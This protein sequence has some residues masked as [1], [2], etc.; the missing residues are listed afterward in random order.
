MFSPTY[1]IF[2][3]KASLTTLSSDLQF[4][5]LHDRTI[6]FPL[7]LL[8]RRIIRT[9]RFQGVIWTSRFLG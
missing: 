3:N 4:Q 6:L 7:S 5:V 8:D 2:Q 9:C 1:S